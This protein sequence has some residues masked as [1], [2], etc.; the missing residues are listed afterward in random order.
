[1]HGEHREGGQVSAKCRVPVS[2]PVPVKSMLQGLGSSWK[3]CCRVPTPGPWRPPPPA[4]LSDHPRRRWRPFRKTRTLAAWKR[5]AL[6]RTS[7][8]QALVCS[9]SQCHRPVP[10]GIRAAWRARDRAVLAPAVTPQAWPASP[11]SPAPSACPPSLLSCVQLRRE[12]FSRR[13]KRTAWRPK[14]CNLQLP[15]YNPTIPAA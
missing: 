7:P 6:L 9:S 4:R 2:A 13:C 12:G 3:C 8:A 11:A 10:T 1:M 5:L 15:V 14:P